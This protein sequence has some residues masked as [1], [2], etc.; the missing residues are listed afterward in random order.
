[1]LAS[2]LVT[3]GKAGIAADNGP[4]RVFIAAI[5]AADR[6]HLPG[7]L[8][9]V[10]FDQGAGELAVTGGRENLAAFAEDVEADFGI[11][12]GV[13]FQHMQAVADFGI[14]ALEELQ[15]SGYGAEEV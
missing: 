14:A 4:L 12:Q 9:A 3:G 11:G 1:M 2:T 7:N 15:A 5:A 8:Q 10:N 13:L 6:R